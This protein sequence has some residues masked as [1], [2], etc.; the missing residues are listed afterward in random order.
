MQ[1]TKQQ[2]IPPLRFPEF[3]GE[4][5]ENELGNCL[6]RKPE[7]GIG[8]SA[9]PFSEKLPTY[10]RI[11]D[12]SEDGWFLEDKKSS[13]AEEVTDDHFL[14]EGDLVFART[15]A[16]VGKTYKYRPEDGPLVFAGFLIRVR[17]NPD[18]LNSELLF[19]LTSSEQYW[20]WVDVTSTRSG[21]PG[22]N[23]TEYSSMP[24]ILPNSVQEQQKIADCLTS[25]DS[26][27]AAETDKLEALQDHKKGLLQQLFPAEGQTT[28]PLR[29]PGFEGDGEWEIYPLE[30]IFDFKVTNSFSRDQLN[31]FSGSVKNIHYG[32]IH[33]KF[34]TLFDIVKE[35]VPFIN[36]SVS[37]EKISLENFCQEGDVIL[38]DA[39]EDEND[40]GKS[41]E[42]INLNDE[43]LLAGLHTILIRQIDQKMIKGFSGYMFKS[44]PIR[45]QI[46]RE[47]QGAKV[48][49]ISKGRLSKVK[50][51]FP[52]SKNE[53]Q[54]IADCLTSADEAIRA[55]E[56]RI[57]SLRDHKKG[58]MQQ[59]FPQTTHP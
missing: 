35:E 7:Y 38:A 24:L 56:E 6:L 15:G 27:L 23:G 4:W 55:Q 48:L 3:E 39:S 44:T 28:P 9:V 59:L 32:D 43:M 16:S 47:S 17:P 29:F 12:I 51:T 40:I 19:Q 50:I 30:D 5:E 21:Q 46:K 36:S 53:Q 11:T 42:I 25:L 58:L 37:I 13:V 22:I 34:Q 8:A 2:L 18:K 57:A 33:T 20:N 41:I 26:L 49:G 54:K 52:E 31:Y 1:P 14:E 10:L 45:N